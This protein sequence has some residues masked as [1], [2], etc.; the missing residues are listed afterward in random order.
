MADKEFWI[1][2]EDRPWDACPNNFDRMHGASIEHVLEDAGAPPIPVTLTSPETG[3][4]TTRTMALPVNQ[5]TQDG[6]SGAKG[7]IAGR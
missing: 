6:A 7:E 1:Q 2:I 3:V 4:T 5:G